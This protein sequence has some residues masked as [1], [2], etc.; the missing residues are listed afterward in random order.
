MTVA[1]VVLAAGQGT[2]FRSD[3]AKVLHRA[4]GRSLLGH[5]LASLQPL[6]LEQVAVVVGHQRA[7]VEAEA[8][9]HNLDGLVF[10]VQ[11][12]QNGTGHAAAQALEV[13]DDRVDRV[14]VVPG[15]APLMTPATLERL[16]GAATDGSSLLLTELDDPTGY[17]RVLRD[18]DGGVRRIV[19]EADA[20][21]AQRAVREVNAGFYV[22][23][24]QPLT[25]ALASLD[26][27]NEQGEQYLTDVIEYLI[28]RDLKVAA[29][30]APPEHVAGCNDRVQL[31]EADR[32]L[33]RRRLH[34]LMR[35]G[36]TVVDPESTW[37]DV[38]VTIGRDAVVH[39]N[40]LLRGDTTIGERAT[41]GPGADL[42][43][44][45]V[46]DGA[47]VRYTVAVGA[48]VG[49]DA[50]VGPFTYLRPGTRLERDAK[51][52]GF[53]ETKNSTIGE[54]AKVPHLSYVGDAE[55]GAGVNFSAGAITV[56][57]DGADKHRTVVEEGAFVGCDTMLVAPVTVGR[58]A[59]VAAGSTITDD[60][61]ADAL[62]IARQR[63]T[64][65]PG[66]ASRRRGAA[67]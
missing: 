63:Q 8:R 4:A 60:V 16:I 42:T 62:A 51:A 36:V 32:I 35:D 6:D 48:S 18:D 47:H 1:A 25:E 7:D 26:A 56:N 15:D 50:Q 12:E 45:T 65:K 27:D 49:P 23:E 40:C 2:R 37:V 43:D 34:S 11:E 38:T 28:G 41:I 3:L 14:L 52:G 5:V 9:E 53:V 57:Y 31:A 39:P 24:R 30:G 29:V 22:F 64:V 33:R 59:F 19:E 10:A 54:G 46:E 20:T 66:W 44:T 61:E 55:L 58:G 21:A 67:D 13:L 17:G